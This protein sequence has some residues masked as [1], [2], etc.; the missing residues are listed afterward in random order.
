MSSDRKF[1]TI[2]AETYYEII[3]ELASA[4]L[5]LHRL[6]A[7]GDHAHKELIE[8]LRNYEFEEDEIQIM[9]DLRIRRNN[10]QYEGKQIP[11]IFLE[12]NEKI[13]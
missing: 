7:K 10:S 8:Y 1:P 12:N 6:S 13:F 4:L 3:K 9:N 11:I 2:I 5:L